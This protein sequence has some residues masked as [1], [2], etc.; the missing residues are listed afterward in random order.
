[1]ALLALFPES[2]EDVERRAEL[3]IGGER[4]MR[5]LAR[6]L[7]GRPGVPGLGALV[8]ARLDRPCCARQLKPMA[9]IAW[10]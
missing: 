10:R 1:M 3:L 4:K 2:D 6:A 5:T 8:M 9:V 7:S